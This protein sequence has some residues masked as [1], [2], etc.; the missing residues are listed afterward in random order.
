[1]QP[2]AFDPCLKISKSDTEFGIAGLQTDDT[3]NLGA[4]EFISKEDNELKKAGFKAKPQN[5]LNDGDSGD[6]NGCR[7]QITKS[8]V[9]ITQKG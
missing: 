4:P 1:M 2:S 9:E 3:L 5:V 7:L 6:F 8:A